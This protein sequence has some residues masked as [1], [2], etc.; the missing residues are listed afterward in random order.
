MLL[1]IR[2]YNVSSLYY[3]QNKVYQIFC[4]YFSLLRSR[5]LIFGYSRLEH[6]FDQV[7]LYERFNVSLGIRDTLSSSV[8]RTTH[9]SLTLQNS[10]VNKD[11]DRYESGTEGDRHVLQ[12]VANGVLWL[13]SSN[14][15]IIRVNQVFS[16][17]NTYSY[18]RFFGV[19]ATSF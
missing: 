11:D 9:L 17:I 5:K 19:F 12:I 10:F 3:Q 16:K 15:A 4:W 13:N 2:N 6:A 14:T 8:Y 7:S 1:Y 18:L